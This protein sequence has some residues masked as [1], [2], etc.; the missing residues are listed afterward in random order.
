MEKDSFHQNSSF[1]LQLVRSFDSEAKQKTENSAK[2]ESDDEFK[3]E[4]SIEEITTTTKK[5]PKSLSSLKI[6]R[7]LI[8]R[9]NLY[10]TIERKLNTL[11]FLSEIV[12]ADL[13]MNV[14]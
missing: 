3:S 2:S 13:I 5:T 7:N 10:K 1:Q 6:K 11:V 9:T 8:T 12:N 14:N 4:K